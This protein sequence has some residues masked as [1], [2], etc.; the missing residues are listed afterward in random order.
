MA[1]KNYKINIGGKTY[2]VEVGDISKSPV[3]VSVNGTMY[4]VEIPESEGHRAS[5]VQGTFAPKPVVAGDPAV[6]RPS[7]PDSLDDGVVIILLPLRER[8][9]G[10]C[11]HLSPVLIIGAR[12]ATELW[13]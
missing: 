8:A 3:E 11:P 6:S 7:I 1:S 5:G 10:L 4:K 2:D 12:D 9:T 13:G